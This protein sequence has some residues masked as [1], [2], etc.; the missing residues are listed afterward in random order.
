MQGAFV[1]SNKLLLTLRLWSLI[2]LTSMKLRGP[3]TPSE[4]SCLVQLPWSQSLQEAL[5]PI[6]R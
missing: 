5:E 4:S 3:I 6:L 2:L 1:G